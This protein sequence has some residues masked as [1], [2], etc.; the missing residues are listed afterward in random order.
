MALVKYNN[1]SISSVTAVG[2]TSGDM[3]LITTN[4]ISSGVTSSS[5]TSS[6]DSTYDTYL[7]KFINIHPATNSQHLQVNFRDGSSAFD[8]TKT[9]TAFYAYQDEAG[10]STDLTYLT[11][12]DLAQSTAYQ[13]ICGTVGNGNDESFS[14]EMFL[15]SP[16]STTFVKHFI[17]RGNTYSQDDLSA[18]MYFAGYCN[19]TAAIDGVDFKFASGNIDSGVIKMYGIKKS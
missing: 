5:F 13:S 18:D 7:F 19:V 15:F 6:I 11:G 8:A 12:L 17:V 4:T 16:S 14:G 1:N 9:T 10:S 2:L 3:N